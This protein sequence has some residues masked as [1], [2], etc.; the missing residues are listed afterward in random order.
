MATPSGL[1]PISGSA[2][3]ALTVGQCAWVTSPFPPPENLRFFGFFWVFPLHFEDFGIFSDSLDI[4]R[5]DTRVYC[6]A[7]SRGTTLQD[8]AAFDI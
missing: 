8:L 3:W 7:V 6:Y 1:R 5:S 2:P 4:A